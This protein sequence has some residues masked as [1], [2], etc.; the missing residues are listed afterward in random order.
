MKK[1]GQGSLAVPPKRVKIA[2][3]D[4]IVWVHADYTGRGPH[5]CFG[6]S[7]PSAH[8]VELFQ[9]LAT[10]PPGKTE[11]TV[12]EWT[13]KWIEYCQLMASIYKEQNQYNAEYVGMV[14]RALRQDWWDM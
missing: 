13:K 11:F 3:Q 12:Q 14:F 10:P 7:D 2:W 5:D 4:V 9:M 1:L 6:M 8:E